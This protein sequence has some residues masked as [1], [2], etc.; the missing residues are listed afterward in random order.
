MRGTMP[1]WPVLALGLCLPD[2]PALA[3]QGQ[4]EEAAAGAAD[5]LLVCWTRH[6]QTGSP[7]I[8]DLGRTQARLLGARLRDMGFKG[9]IYASPYPRTAATADVIA[10]ELGCAFYLAPPIREVVKDADSMNRF[11]GKTLEYFREKYRNLAP[12]ATLPYPWWTTDREDSHKVLARVTPFLNSLIEAPQQDILLVGHAAS[13]GAMGRYWAGRAKRVCE[14]NAGG[15]WN[16]ALNAVELGRENRVVHLN[17]TAHLADE[18]VTA[19][20]LTKAAWRR[21]QEEKQE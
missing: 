12:D 7:D 2:G 14:R 13:V 18:Q 21:R 10:G 6:G 1:G 5:R 19:N 20:S 15:N 16:C 9:T 3:G 8:T 4:S 17:D 11:T